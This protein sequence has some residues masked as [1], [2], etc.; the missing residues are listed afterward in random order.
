MPKYN[1]INQPGENIPENIQEILKKIF[2]SKDL[3]KLE[4]F[5]GRIQ[6]SLTAPYTDRKKQKSAVN[7]DDT[8][9]KRIIYDL[10]FAENE[11]E[12]LTKEQLKKVANLLDFPVS[13]KANTEEVRKNILEFLLSNK[14]WKGISSE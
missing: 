13:S 12:F 4:K 5:G 6:V 10:N 9:I 7:I 2:A 1:L 11:L 14:R 8:F 3:E